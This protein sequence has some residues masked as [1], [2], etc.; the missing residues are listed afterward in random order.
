L[1]SFASQKDLSGIHKKLYNMDIVINLTKDD[2]VTMKLGNNFAI[3]TG[4][5]MITFTLD[6][7]DE[8]LN[9][10]ENI[11]SGKLEGYIPKKEE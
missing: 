3:K 9:D 10:I 7:V 8:L 11:K 1:N 6:A 2:I 4:N 5:L